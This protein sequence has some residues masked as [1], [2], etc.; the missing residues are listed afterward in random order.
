MGMFR[1]MLLRHAKATPFGPTGDHERSLTD[2]GRGDARRLGEYL[3]A[4]GMAPDFAAIS[5]ARRTRETWDIVSDGWKNV[6]V[7]L[8]P[9][10]Y[11][12][13]LSALWTL[14]RQSPDEKRVM[15]CVGHNPGFADLAAELI[16]YGDRYA[17]ARMRHH[18]PTC[19]L[20]VLDL[21]LDSWSQAE[22]GV[23]RLDR[24]VTPKTL[25]GIDD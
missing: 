3:A 20:A 18:F 21:N 14:L 13:P 10:I 25:G 23:A 1:L 15:I 16:G 17:Q 2:R 12:A 11:E 5:D 8:E 22:P 19:G 7:R 6:P 9:R 4:E 24:F